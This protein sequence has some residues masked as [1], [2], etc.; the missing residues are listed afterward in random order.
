MEYHYEHLTVSG[1]LL[2]PHPAAWAETRFAYATALGDAGG[3]D[4]FF[5]VRRGI[6][7]HYEAL[8]LQQILS[9][10]RLSH[11][12]PRI[13]SDCLPALWKRLSEGPGPL[14]EEVVATVR[15]VWER[16]Y[17]IR[18]EVDLA[19]ELALLAHGYQGY[20]EALRLFQASER[21]YGPDARARWNMGL[22]HYA[23]GEM[24]PAL[25][26]FADARGL[27]G[28]FVPS[29]AVQVKGGG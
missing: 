5:A 22:C 17:F 21:L 12:D 16:Y 10:I 7:D 13:L 24:E 19:F 2:G 3:P 29:R 15:R 28:D 9:L 26:C 11:W 25:R 4:D 6:Q 27:D 18:E 8:G 1:F 23:L 14:R 20:A